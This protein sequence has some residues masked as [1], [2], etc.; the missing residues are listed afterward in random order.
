MA[1]SSSNRFT[2]WPAAVNA[3]AGESATDLSPLDV[4]PSD[5]NG[6]EREDL[7]WIDRANG[8]AYVALAMSPR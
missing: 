5:V 7:V 6:D 1:G 4:L 3:V 8:R 2:L